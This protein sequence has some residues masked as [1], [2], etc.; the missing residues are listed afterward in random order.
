MQQRI[1][2]S[3]PVISVICL[4]ARDRSPIRASHLI[5]MLLI[6]KADG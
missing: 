3:F 1:I 5:N 4:E 2:I 6:C